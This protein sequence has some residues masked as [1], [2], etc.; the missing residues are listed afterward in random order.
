MRYGDMN[1][2]NL[3]IVEGEN[4]KLYGPVIMWNNCHCIQHI[5]SAFWAIAYCVLLWTVTPLLHERWMIYFSANNLCFWLF[6]KPLY[7]DT[8]I[9]THMHMDWKYLNFSSKLKVSLEN[10][11]RFMIIRSWWLL[12]WLVFLIMK[13]AECCNCFWC[14]CSRKK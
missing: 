2:L 8:Y 5:C 13:I 7:V 11:T 6:D 14:W 3:C 12:F 1:G 4:C 10:L 9:Y